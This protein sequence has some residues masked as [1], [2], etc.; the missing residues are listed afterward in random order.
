FAKSTQSAT[1]KNLQA[2]RHAWF[3]SAVG[4]ACPDSSP[5]LDP[6]SLLPSPGNPSQNCPLC[7]GACLEYVH[8]FPQLSGIVNC[9]PEQL[10]QW[11]T[12]VGKAKIVN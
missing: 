12:V 10:A 3:S 8:C 1:K 11:L 4:E 2:H 9:P 5:G 6:V 7:V